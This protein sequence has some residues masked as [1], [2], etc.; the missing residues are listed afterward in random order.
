MGIEPTRRRVDDASKDL[1]AAGPE[2]QVA[3]SQALSENCKSRSTT[4]CTKEQQEPSSAGALP[5]DLRRVVEAWPELPDAVK[6]GIVAMVKAAM[7]AH[8]AR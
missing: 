5:T 3:Q 7:N 8:G 6:A 4:D 1:K 2:A